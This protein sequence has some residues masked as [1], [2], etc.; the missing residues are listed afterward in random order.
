MFFLG[1]FGDFIEFVQERG[2]GQTLN[3]YREAHHT[4]GDGHNLIALRNFWRQSE[5]QRQSQSAAQTAPE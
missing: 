4:K 3:Q 5:R 2:D 1:V